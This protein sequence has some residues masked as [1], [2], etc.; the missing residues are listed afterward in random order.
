MGFQPWIFEIDEK[1][2][3]VVITL[4][5]ITF[6]FAWYKHEFFRRIGTVLSIFIIIIGLAQVKVLPGFFS[7]LLTVIGI[8]LEIIL[9]RNELKSI[10]SQFIKAM[11]GYIKE[12][13]Q[14]IKQTTLNFLIY[15]WGLRWTFIGIIGVFCN[16]YGLLLLIPPTDLWGIVW[17]I[18]GFALII[19]VWNREILLFLEKCT[20][21][22]NQVITALSK[23]VSQVYNQ[24]KILT[25]SVIDSIVVIAIITLG[26]FALGYGVILLISG[27][28]DN[29][30]QWTSGIRD[31]NIAGD[32]IWLIASFAQGK[33]FAINEVSNLLGIW[34]PGPD[35]VPTSS[36]VL[37]LIGTMFAGFG[38]LLPLFSFR[39]RD[40]IKISVLKQRFGSS[41]SPEQQ[42]EYEDKEV[43]K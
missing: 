21:V 7:W 9:W 40:S 23:F 4:G 2:S 1:L 29:T 5:F 25:R 10:I 39:R 6:I 17:L 11:V 14:A 32:I 43:T 30:G 15:V 27:I 24:L 36:I 31:V 12:T 37:I 22:I 13:V 16:L 8:V 42:I 35:G 18:V 28:F 41:S 19:I 26:F 34:A 38:V 33:P 20:K 3:F